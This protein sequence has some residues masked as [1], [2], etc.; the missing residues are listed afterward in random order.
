MRKSMVLIV[1]C[2]APWM[3]GMGM[4]WV[5]PDTRMQAPRHRVDQI[6]SICGKGRSVFDEDG[7]R[8]DLHATEGL[9]ARK[10]I[11]PTISNGFPKNARLT[12]GWRPAARVA[13][14][15]AAVFRGAIALQAA[16]TTA[17]IRRF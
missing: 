7:D 2:S 13:A 16:N 4:A 17:Q 10:C 14:F 1:P 3:P 5:D 8:Q 11:Q 12:P 6:R 15:R 9:D